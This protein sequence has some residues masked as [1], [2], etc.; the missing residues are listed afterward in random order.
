MFSG[1]ISVGVGRATPDLPGPSTSTGTCKM[2]PMQV[3]QNRR[4][5]SESSIIEGTIPAG[6]AKK[7]KTT[8]PETEETEGLSTAEL[9]RL[10]LLEQLKLIRMQQQQKQASESDSD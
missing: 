6:P 2:K 10:V 9:Q 5:F 4:T 8:L 7:R 1:A 3:S